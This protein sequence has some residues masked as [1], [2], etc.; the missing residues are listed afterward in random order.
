MYGYTDNIAR[1]NLTSGTVQ[2]EH[3][4]ERFYRQYLGGRNII[5]YILQKEVGPE[6]DPLGPENKFIVATSMMTGSPIAGSSRFSIG[7]KAP[8]TGGFGESEAGGFFGPELRYA[9]FDA[10]IIEGVSDFPCYIWIKDGKIEIRDASAL[11][12]KETGEVEDLIQAELNDGKCRILQAGIA[13]ENL[14]KYASVSSSLR[15]WCGRGGLGA[16]MGSK[17]L[18]AIAARATNR[19]I[20]IANPEKVKEFVRWFAKAHK[21]NEGILFKGEYGTAGGADSMDASGMLPTF[22]FRSG[23][24]D[25]AKEIG[26]I[27]MHD[28]MLS[29]RGGCLYCPIR[30]KRVINYHDKD[31]TIE[32]RYGG[33]EY[34]TTGCLGSNCG[35]KSLKHVCKANELCGRY[36]ID[37]ISTGDTISF[38]MECFEN[39]LL[40]LDDTD[41]MDLSFGNEESFLKVIGMIARREGKLGNLLAEGSW[42]ASRII[43]EETWKYSMTCRKQEFPAHEPRGKWGVAFGYA[44]SATGADHLIAAHDPWFEGK[45]NLEEQYT[46]MDIYPMREFG[47]FDPLPAMSLDSKKVRLFTHLQLMWGLYNMLDLCIFVGVPEYRMTTIDQWVQVINDI[48][49]WDLS[50]WELIKASER[51]IQLQR[52]YNVRNGLGKEF[53]TL[54]DRMFEPVEAGAHKGHHLERETFQKAIITY[55]EMLGWNQEGVP[56]FGKFAELGMEDMYI[57]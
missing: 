36:G 46:Y 29:D 32:G 4:G 24:F 30:C 50:F 8:L 3:W 55:Y 43:G 13:G 10:L 53:D 25:H 47:I 44:V 34:E 42:R 7:A 40:T 48:T 56:S 21:E 57:L 22:N 31:M 38:A 11:W 6:V 12:G 35:I 17:K 41:G 16:V 14:V 54:P 19:Q 28:E 15:H 39:G 52:I 1:I 2:V 37:T 27:T 23:T 49:G 51:G 5:G 33:P 26:G 18:K 20:P 9:G 45:P